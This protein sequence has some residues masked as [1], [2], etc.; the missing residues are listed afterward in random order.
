MVVL[1]ALGSGNFP[2]MGRLCCGYRTKPRKCGCFHLA[3]SIDA[4]YIPRKVVKFGDEGTM[5]DRVA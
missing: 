4:V 1:M 5:S 2:T 3:T